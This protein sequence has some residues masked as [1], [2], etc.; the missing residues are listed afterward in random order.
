[1]RCSHISWSLGSASRKSFPVF[2][3]RAQ[4]WAWRSRAT[5]GE[6]TRS[7]R[8]RSMSAR[9]WQDGLSL[10]LVF[11]CDHPVPDSSAFH[12][13]HAALLLGLFDCAPRKRSTFG[14]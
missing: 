4:A 8:L 12:G 2:L 14:L 6:S 1:M 5:D 10:L 9:R 3:L 7:A 13:A 11:S